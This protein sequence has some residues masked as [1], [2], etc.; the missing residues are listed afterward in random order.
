[1]PVFEGTLL[2]EYVGITVKLCNVANDFELFMQKIRT[3]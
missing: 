2:Y 1:M 3:Y